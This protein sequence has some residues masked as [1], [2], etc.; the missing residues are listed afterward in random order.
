MPKKHQFQEGW[1][2]PAC[3][4]ERLT[5]GGP[6]PC[7]GLLLRLGIIVKSIDYDDGRKRREFR[8][9]RRVK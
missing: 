8:Q 3:G 6:D 4:E 7:L 9:R 1:K 2:C 5:T